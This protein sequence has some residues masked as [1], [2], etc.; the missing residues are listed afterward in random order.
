MKISVILCTYNR[1][2][3]L[4]KALGGIAG[5]ALPESDECEILVVDNNSSDQT[6][7]VVKEFCQRYPDRFRYVFE[8]QQGLSH[9]RNR[10][11]SESRG[12]AL[13]FLDDD[14]TIAP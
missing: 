8:A 6:H 5:Q 4:Q 12:D 3:L 7:D 1:S 2:R 11:I 13:V 14:V 9:A 10:G